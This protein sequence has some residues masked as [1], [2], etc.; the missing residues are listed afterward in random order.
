[1]QGKLRETQPPSLLRTPER[2]RSA[3][4]MSIGNHQLQPAEP[5]WAGAVGLQT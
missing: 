1:M 4:H 2:Q 3:R 5:Q